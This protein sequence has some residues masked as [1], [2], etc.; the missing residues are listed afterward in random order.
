MTGVYVGF[1]N[2]SIS[3]STSFRYFFIAFSSSVVSLSF[4]CDSSYNLVSFMIPDGL[5]AFKSKHISLSLSELEQPLLLSPMGGVTG[6]HFAIMCHKKY[7]PYLSNCCNSQSSRTFPSADGFIT[8]EILYT[9]DNGTYFFPTGIRK[10]SGKRFYISREEP[11]MEGQHMDSKSRRVYLCYS[12][13]RSSSI[14]NTF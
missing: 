14:Y 8:S 12:G 3:S 1:L 2:S 10:L 7:A 11:Y 13:K 4:N 6:W 9:D 5:L